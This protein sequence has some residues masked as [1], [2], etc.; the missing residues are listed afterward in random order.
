MAPTESDLNPQSSSASTQWPR[1]RYRVLALLCMMASITFLDRNCL[2][3]NKSLIGKQLGISQTQWSWIFGAFVLTYG[4]TQIP[5]GVLAEKFGHRLL[6]TLMVGWWSAFTI[7]TGFADAISTWPLFGGIMKPLLAAVQ[8]PEISLT[9][10]S[11]FLIQLLFGLGEGGAYPAMSGVVSR[12][13][14]ATEKG[15][16]QGFIWGFSRFGGALC[17]LIV[18]PLQK[19]FLNNDWRPVF[20]IMG[21]A[22]ILWSL[23]WAAWYRNNP[24]EMPGIT[25]EELAEINAGRKPRSLAPVP[26]GALF[27]SRQLWLILAMYWCYVWGSWFYFSWMPTYLR[28][29]RGFSEDNAKWFLALPFALGIFSNVLGGWLSDSLCRRYGVKF[30]RRCMGSIPLAIAGLLLGCA[31]LLPQ[32]ANLSVGILLGISFGVMDLMLPSAW[33][34]C[35]D[36]SGQHAAVVSGAMNAAGSFGGFSLAMSFGYIV[37]YTGFM[38]A[39]LLIAFMLLVASLLFTRINPERPLFS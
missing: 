19:K 10:A 7:L 34:V 15:L 4:I 32:G 30:G 36:V 25:A 21:G 35:M 22:G 14:P 33:A 17:P 11:L 5:L 23:M 28:E 8:H 16:A 31:A 2:S 1:Q 6:V 9:V 3:V 38:Q 13:F 29:G 39:V 18:V 12:W 26:W 27:R 37:H 20:W 24:A